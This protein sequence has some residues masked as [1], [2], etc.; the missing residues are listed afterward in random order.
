V[1]D[2]TFSGLKK[3][4]PNGPVIITFPNCRINLMTD[5][6]PEKSSRAS[7][8]PAALYFLDQNRYNVVEVAND[9]VRGDL[10]DRCLLVLVYG[11]D[12]V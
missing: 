5:P 2:F 9:A 10:E 6:V 8:P 12:Y 1:K 3:P 4:A 11:D 7:L